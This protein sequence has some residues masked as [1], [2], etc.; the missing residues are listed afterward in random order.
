MKLVLIDRDGVVNEELL[1]YVKSPD[2]LIILPA[3]LE[4][5]AWLHRH[6]FTCVVVT[7]QSVVGR[8]IIPL[9]TLENIHLHLSETVASHGGKISDV[10]ACTDH[11]DRAT[12]RRKPKPG[13]LLEALEKYGASPESTPFIG[14]AVTDMEAAAAAGCPRY[15][16]MTGKGRKTSSLLPE[17]VKPVTPCENL[18]DAARHIVQTYRA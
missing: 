16:V 6:G 12:Y 5:L 10:I 9:Q 3:A 18:A 2:E 17:S 1:Y 14:D 7:N 4:G 13:M 15:L 8:N 11:P